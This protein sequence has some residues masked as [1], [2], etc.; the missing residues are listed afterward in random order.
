[1]ST[2]DRFYAPG[3]STDWR[4]YL[5]AVLFSLYLGVLG[6]TR[7]DEDR[8]TSVVAFGLAFIGGVIALVIG[9]EG[10]NNATAVTSLIVGPP[11]AIV[12]MLGLANRRRAKA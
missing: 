3:M 12:T 9:V 6:G 7:R 10:I 8:T 2:V 4:V 5:I 1:M 11:A